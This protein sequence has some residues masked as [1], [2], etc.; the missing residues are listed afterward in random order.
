MQEIPPNPSKNNHLTFK[1]FTLFILVIVSWVATMFVRGVII[2]REGTKQAVA[3]QISE[4]WSRPQLI[5]GPV[6][7]VPIEKTVVAT[8]G[9]RVI[10]TST[11]TLLPEKLNYQS[12]VATE[13]RK[14]GVYSTPV[15]NATVVGSGNFDLAEIMR[16]TDSNTN[17]LW[18][19]AQ[20]SINVSDTRGITSL[21]SIKLN[22]KD[23]PMLPASK[24][25]TFGANGVHTNISLDPN[26]PKLPFAFSMPLKGSQEISFLPLGEETSVILTSDWKDPSFS[27]EFLP[28]ERKLTDNGFSAM[29]KITS[30]GK[31]LPQSWQNNLT[32][33]DRESLASKSFGVSLHQEVNFYTM[34]DRSTKYSI[35][36]ITLTFLTFFLYEVLSGLRIHPLQYLLVGMAI[37]LFYLLLLSLAEVVGFLPAYIGGAS[38]ITI[39]ITSYCR[40]VLKAKTRALAIGGLLVALYSYL[41]ILL[42][43]EQLSLLFGS[44]LLLGVL[45]IVM[46]ITRNIDWYSL[47]KN[48]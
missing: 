47:S 38:T 43:L 42:Q 37:A 48:G 1:V 14:R 22:S 27:G 8:T 2:E 13:L 33:V 32:E 5:A 28:T 31:N 6:I 20:I 36:F 9:E 41:Y 25:L 34:V 11:I 30:Y 12:Q 39:L 17:I 7:T 46:Y 15:Y 19:Q 45:T 3:E 24:F 16:K 44:A 29:W 26:Q 10:N 40:S 18:D 35:L 23:Y 21:F 4:Q